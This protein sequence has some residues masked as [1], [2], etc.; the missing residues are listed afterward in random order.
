MR[1]TLRRDAAADLYE[2]SRELHFEKRD[3]FRD[4]LDAFRTKAAG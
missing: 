4:W 3:A 1:W 2:E